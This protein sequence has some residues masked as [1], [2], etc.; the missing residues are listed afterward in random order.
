MGFWSLKEQIFNTVMIC[1]NKKLLTQWRNIIWHFPGHYISWLMSEMMFYW[2]KVE[3]TNL[4]RARR[5]VERQFAWSWKKM[6]GEG[7]F[8][9]W[10]IK[11]LTKTF[12]KC[13]KCVAIV[14]GRRIHFPCNNKKGLFQNELFLNTKYKGVKSHN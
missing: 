10:N 9:V 8:I 13:Y 2:L 7:C 3:N 14:Q 5:F 4:W 1:S 12:Q 11:M 6:K